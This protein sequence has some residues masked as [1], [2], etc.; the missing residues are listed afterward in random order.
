M[1]A[2]SPSWTVI[3]TSAFVAGIGFGGIDFGL[4]QL[5]SEYFV[6]KKSTAS[7]NALHGCFGAGSVAGPLLVSAMGASYSWTFLIVTAFIVAAAIMCYWL[8]EVKVG[9]TLQPKGADTQSVIL[10]DGRRGCPGSKQSNEQAAQ[11][12]EKEDTSQATTHLHEQPWATPS[13]SSHAHI[14]HLQRNSQ[15]GNRRNCQS[16]TPPSHATT[17][18]HHRESPSERR[19]A[20]LKRG[21]T[22][23]SSTWL[24]AMLSGLG[25]IT[26]A[27]FMVIY[28]LHVGI[29]TGVG[30]WEQTHL[31][32]IGHSEQAAYFWV[33]TFWLAMTISRFAVAPIALVVSEK[34]IV[35]ACLLGMTLSLGAGIVDDLAVI[36]YICVGIFIGP[37]FP[38][39][40]PWLVRMFPQLQ[41]ATA[42]VIALSMVGGVAFPPALGAAIS[43]FGITALPLTLTVLSGVCVVAFAIIVKS[44]KR[45][46]PSIHP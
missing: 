13:Q 6:G 20:L 37:I 33:S 22:A 34:N 1:L 27:C 2:L 15:A 9:H 29:E 26:L 5:F 43:S 38:T 46:A 32:A 25:K 41:G 45:L 17:A 42:Y 31:E 18:P 16:A 4:N 44:E 7:L 23:S 35:L 28:I 14:D 10:S 19:A 11:Q 30:G 8:P 36:S 3:A 39:C 21:D 12:V 24:S 40:I